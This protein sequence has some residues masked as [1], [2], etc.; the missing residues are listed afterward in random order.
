MK[1]RGQFFTID[2]FVA[3]ALIA[4]GVF[5]L[6]TAKPPEQFRSQTATLSSDLMNSLST[7]KV[8]QVDNDLLFEM[9]K[10]KNVTNLDASILELIVE[11][12][13]YGQEAKARSLLAN[14]TAESLPLQYAFS[15]YI[16]D[17]FFYQSRPFDNETP[18][19]ITTRRI[20]SGVKNSTEF[21]GPIKV[22]TRVW[23]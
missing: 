3:L 10:A 1:K 7:I 14:L 4:V 21:W 9:I 20:V 6:F 23:R 12:K 18:T 17:S 11:M 5:V 13:I 15:M 2:V 8:N 19:L 16:N 22:E